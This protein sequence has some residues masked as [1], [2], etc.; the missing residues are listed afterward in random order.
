MPSHKYQDL[1]Q[2]AQFELRLEQLCMKR[3]LQ[4]LPL[5]APL[6]LLKLRFFYDLLLCFLGADFGFQVLLL[7]L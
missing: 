5:Q 7:L 3:L 4:V 6:S 2:E 1:H